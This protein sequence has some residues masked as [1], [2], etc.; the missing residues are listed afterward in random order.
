MRL[1]RY[2]VTCFFRYLSDVAASSCFSASFEYEAWTVALEIAVL[3]HGDVVFATRCGLA[4]ESPMF[5][6]EVFGFLGFVRFWRRRIFSAYPSH[7]VSVDANVVFVVLVDECLSL[8]QSKGSCIAF[9]LDDLLKRVVA[10][11]FTMN[12]RVPVFFE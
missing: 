6:A 1:R 9:F 8:Q 12:M 10:R 2:F 5:L 11:H 4:G 7:V 3:G